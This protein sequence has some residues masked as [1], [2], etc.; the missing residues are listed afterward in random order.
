MKI[1][2]FDTKEIENLG[3]QD[4][5]DKIAEMMGYNCTKVRYNLHKIEIARSI[6]DTQEKY[7]TEIREPKLTKEEFNLIALNY[8]AVVNDGLKENTIKVYNGFIMQLEK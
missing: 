4:L 6:F 3:I 2:H 8:G 1:F 5:Y 7:Y